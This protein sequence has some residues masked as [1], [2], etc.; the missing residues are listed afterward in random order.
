MFLCSGTVETENASKYL[1]QLC[2][3]FAHKVEVEYDAASARVQFPP[4]L[5][6]MTA[7]DNVLSFY[8]RSEQDLGLDVIQSIIDKHL[9]KFAWREE[10]AVDWARGMPDAAPAQVTSELAAS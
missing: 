4:G 9:A 10:I 5:C 1:Q 7:E 3:H 6:L 8:C 2:K